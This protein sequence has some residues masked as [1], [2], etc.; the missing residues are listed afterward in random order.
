M[1]VK[2]TPLNKMATLNSNEIQPHS[3]LYTGVNPDIC[4][5]GAKPSSGSL[6][7]EVWGTL[8]RVFYFSKCKNDKY[9]IKANLVG[10]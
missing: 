4:E 3:A 8:Y 10:L 1:D 5:R 9:K 7:Q 6:N 2:D